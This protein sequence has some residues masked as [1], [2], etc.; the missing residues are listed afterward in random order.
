[1][2]KEHRDMVHEYHYSNSPMTKT[3]PE[4]GHKHVPLKMDNTSI[5]PEHVLLQTG[6]N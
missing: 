4:L 6:M 2:P 3:L 1:M 5:L